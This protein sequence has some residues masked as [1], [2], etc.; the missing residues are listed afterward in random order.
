M[1]RLFLALLFVSLTQHID[2]PI[3]LAEEVVVPQRGTRLSIFSNG[4]SRR[5]LHGLF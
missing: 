2:V 5:S 1:Y 3:A 4:K